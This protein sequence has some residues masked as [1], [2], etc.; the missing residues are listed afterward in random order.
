M[1]WLSFLGIV[2]A[3]VLLVLMAFKGFNIVFT[4]IVASVV[5][6]ILSGLN[7]LTTMKTTYMGLITVSGGTWPADSWAAAKAT[8]AIGGFLGLLRSY[9]LLFVLSGT[10]GKFMAQCGAVKTLANLLSKLTKFSKSPA[11]ISV[12]IMVALYFILSYIGINGF[13]TVFTLLGIGYELFKK[14]DCPWELYYYGSAGIMGAAVLPYSLYTSNIMA[15][16]NMQVGLAAAPVMSV[17]MVVVYFVLVA[18]MA[19]IDVVR[20]NKHGDGFLPSGATY[21]ANPTITSASNENIPGTLNALIPMLVP[22]VC[23]LLKLDVLYA[24]LLGIVACIAF[25]HDKF[26]GTAG[27]RKS[28]SEGFALSVTAVANVAAMNALIAVMRSTSGYRMIVAFFGLAPGIWGVL[29]VGLLTGAIVGSQSSFLPTTMGDM[30]TRIGV[31][32][33][34]PGVA[35][36]LAIFSGCAYCTPHNSGNVNAIILTKGNYLKAA[37]CYIRANFVPG[38]ITLIIFTLLGEAGIFG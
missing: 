18:V 23:I 33:L 14:T 25:N 37:L 20:L 12:M 15:N 26:G 7:P 32:G 2:I 34:N 28:V 9:L 21:D 16:D 36:R 22:I 35:S 5:I 29:L 31:T 17:L 11:H 38:I 6:C 27:M 19:K 4:S 13:V 10:F 3:V 8:T 1:E 24:L 30:M